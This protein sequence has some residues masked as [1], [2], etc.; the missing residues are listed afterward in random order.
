MEYT[1]QLSEL[2][3][4]IHGFL[5][6]SF[7][8]IKFEEA[9]DNDGLSQYMFSIDGYFEASDSMKEK[10]I[11]DF[12]RMERFRRDDNFEDFCLAAYQQIELI[13]STLITMMIQ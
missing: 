8:L 3:R 2:D 5:I 12:I 11:Q 1:K 7:P 13:I 9:K 4:R 10:L 6:E